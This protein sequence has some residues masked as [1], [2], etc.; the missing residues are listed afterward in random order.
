MIGCA[1][2][3]AVMDQV[4]LPGDRLS[5]QSARGRPWA[6]VR[7]AW[8]PS[9]EQGQLPIRATQW[10]Q[11]RL[12]DGFFFTSKRAIAVRHGRDGQTLGVGV[13]V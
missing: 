11:V 6:V 10:A 12:L 3:W 5:R 1:G 9:A 7:T 8:C 4:L 13:Q 2:C